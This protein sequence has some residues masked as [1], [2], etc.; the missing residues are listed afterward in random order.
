MRGSIHKNSKKRSCQL[1]TAGKYSAQSL[2][3]FK[4]PTK[5]ENYGGYKSEVQTFPVSTLSKS[6]IETSE[7]I[8]KL[9][10]LTTYPVNRNSETFG[11]GLS[12]EAVDYE[13][14]LVLAIGTKRMLSLYQNSESLPLRVGSFAIL[15]TRVCSFI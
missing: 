11:S 8:K 3:S 14:D 15:M 1:K 2:G 4:T 7:E 12:I 5:Y 9:M 10:S 13:P 6:S